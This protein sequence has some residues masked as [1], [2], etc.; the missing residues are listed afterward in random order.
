[1]RFAIGDP[2]FDR[3]PGR[4]DGLDGLD[5]LDI[6][7]RRWRV[8][9]LDDAPKAVEAEEDRVAMRRMVDWLFWDEGIF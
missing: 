2:L 6:E 7:W 8:R 4:F 1:M 9:E 3:L 5:G